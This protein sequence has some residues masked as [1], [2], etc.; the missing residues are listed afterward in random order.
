LATRLLREFDTRRRDNDAR[1]VD[2]ACTSLELYRAACA[3]SR[4]WLA[5]RELVVAS[6]DPDAAEGIEP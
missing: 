1:I 6:L 4:T 5:A 2:G 3:V